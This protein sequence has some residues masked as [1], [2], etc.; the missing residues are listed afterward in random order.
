MAPPVKPT[1]IKE[2]KP[3]T[4]S[5]PVGKSTSAKPAFAGADANTG[6]TPK[7]GKPRQAQA[8][9]KRT[10]N[11]PGHPARVL[12]AAAIAAVLEE[13]IV[14]DT[15][16]ESQSA[17][18][19]SVKLEPRDRALARSIA[20]ASLRNLGAIRKILARFL[21]KGMPRKSGTLEYN[22]ITGAAQV[23]YMDVPDHAA[24]DIAVELCREN[25]NAAAFAALANAVLRNIIRGRDT[26]L[27][28]IDPLH[29]NTP[30]WI[31]KSWIAAYGEATA[32]AIATANSAEPTL[33]LT[34]K[35]EASHW[36]EKLGGIVL[37]TGSVRLLTHE[38][39]SD[40]EGYAEGA[41]WVQDAAAALP[42]KVLQAR[43]QETIADLCAAPGGK[44]AQLAL[45]GA[46]VTAF[47]R[48][49]ERLIRLHANLTRLKLTADI[50]AIDVFD[51]SPQTYLFDAILLDAPCSASGTMRRHPDVTWLK[52]PEDVRL[53]ALMQA[54]MLDKALSLLKPDGRLVYC[55]C[56]LQPE[57]GPA[58]IEALLARNPKFKRVPITADETGLAEVITPEGDIRTLPC[59][60]ANENPRLSGLDGFFVSRLARA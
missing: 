4:G 29:D 53:L 25:R 23:L 55:V 50:D 24:V 10:S 48:S 14:L 27:A 18:P 1:F 39:I 47:D 35:S 31:A 60:L 32:R 36:A 9:P 49:K 26:L 42:A 6:G 17:A 57:E 40:L 41:W 5:K 59:H 34:V 54:K 13:R 12:A 33:D 15:W 3:R 8:N 19:N 30:P 2:F 21:V 52:Q 44:T 22:L 28:E 46:E 16:F 38:A 37:P 43:P 20:L 56:S 7:S 58:Q 11:A 45:A 51:L